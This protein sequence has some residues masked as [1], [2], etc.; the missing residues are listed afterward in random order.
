MCLQHLQHRLV[1]PAVQRAEQRVDPGRHRREQVG[2]AGA[3]QPD[4]RGRAVLLVVGVQHE[5]HVQHPGED[6]VDLV[7]G[8]RHPERHAQEVLDVPEGVVRVQQRLPDRRLVRVRS[9][10]GQLGQQPDGGHVDLLVV[11]RVQA[12]LVERRQRADRRGQ[13]RHRVRVA[14]EAVEEPAHL[15][16]QQGVYL[17][18]L[19]ELRQL[20]AASA[21]PRRSAGRRPPGT[22]TSPRVAR[23]GTPGSAGSPRPRRCR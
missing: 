13:H 12:V 3:D 4:G 21:A 10:R 17:D 19:A 14:R 23:S 16:A 7:R 5:Q 11:E 2:V 22:T 1:G 9:D 6:R 18:P 15:L 20:R 8:G